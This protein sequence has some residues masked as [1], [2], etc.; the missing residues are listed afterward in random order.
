MLKEQLTKVAAPRIK[1]VSAP[2]TDDGH[3]YV[4]MLSGRELQESIA[5]EKNKDF[6]DKHGTMSPML[7]LLAYCTCDHSGESNL[8]PGDAHLLSDLPFPVL[9]RLQDAA[10]ELNG[11]SEEWREAEKKG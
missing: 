1:K 11:L 2:E 5:L 4:R 10:L 6:T 8:D 9:M 7:A 3:M